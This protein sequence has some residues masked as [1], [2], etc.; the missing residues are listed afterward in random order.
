M[1]ILVQSPTGHGQMIIKENVGKGVRQRDEE[2][3]MDDD[4]ESELTEL[5]GIPK[6]R[7][8][9]RKAPSRKRGVPK[10]TTVVMLSEPRTRLC[11]RCEAQSQ[12]CMPRS[13]GGEPLE[14][15]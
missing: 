3:T 14:A 10:N 13:K 9:G 6:T 15:C 8:A 2:T 1:V 4:G 7:R 11:D 12:L 5:L